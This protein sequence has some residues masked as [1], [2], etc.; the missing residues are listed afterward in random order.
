[1]TSKSSKLLAKALEF[2][3]GP[4]A[5]DER[6]DTLVLRGSFVSAEE[7]AEWLGLRRDPP[8]PFI[9]LEIHNPDIGG[10]LE[11]GDEFTDGQNYVITVEKPK[12]D[13]VA[14]F[15]F[16]EGAIK[17]LQADG[18][19]RQ[20][21]V[22][23]FADDA[24]FR[25]RGFDVSRWDLDAAL[26]SPP[27]RESISP[28]KLVS[29]YVPTRE[30]TPD[31]APWIRTTPPV[32]C[33][34]LYQSWQA[35]AARRLLG[36]LVSSA[37]WEKDQ[38]WLQASGPPV[39]RIPADD[40][41][42][43]AAWEPLT[44]AAMW[45][46]LSGS[47]IEARHR[48]FTSEL[49]RADRPGQVFIETLKRARE[50]AD[51]AYAA[52]IQSSSRETLKALGD[53]RKTVIEETQKVSQRAQDLTAGLWKDVAVTTTPFVLRLFPDAGK[54]ASLSISAYFYFAAAV[55]ISL[56]YGLQWRINGAF[57]KSQEQSRARWFQ[58]LYTYI[59]ARERE[60]IAE[61][62]INQAMKNYRETRNVLLV[63]YALLIA[64]LVSVGWADLHEKPVPAANK[65][66]Q[67]VALPITTGINTGQSGAVPPSPKLSPL[68][69]PAPVSATAPAPN[70][71]PPESKTPAIQPKVKAP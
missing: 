60:E 50:A 13:G 70:P 30:I 54:I 42:I 12:T 40:S 66:P 11:D 49:A 45:V 56:S 35:V 69:M 36:G 48:L 37:W 59:S 34:A 14:Y 26:V 33:S 57:F 7:Q 62:P 61:E 23:G 9:G 24:A 20:I 63:V 3:D 18:Q 65:S 5:V 51:V 19:P 28:A 15:L 53:L 44:D 58:T 38:V 4:G 41:S 10:D 21:L 29:D 52:H 8:A 46:Y 22:A 71:G 16:E 43:A 17:S 32:H 6:V 31:L 47:D 64:I 39:F 55:F 1:M 27:N 25:T 67:G 68:A 2:R